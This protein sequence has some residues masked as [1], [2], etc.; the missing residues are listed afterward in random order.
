MSLFKFGNLEMEIDFTDVDVA[1]SLEDAAEILN[2]EVKK[3]PLTGKNSEV[4][5]AQNVCYDHYFD[6]IFRQGASG[7]MF[8]T[9]SLSQR[10]EAVKLFADLKFQSDHELSEKLS[11]YR[12][13]KAGNRQQRRNYERQHRNRP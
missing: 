11:S 13:N 8:R 12:V 2:E 10:L 9:G 1:K 4:I 3:L 6:H 7:K 5:R